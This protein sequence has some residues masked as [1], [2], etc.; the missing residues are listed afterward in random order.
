MVIV[1]DPATGR[2]KRL[3][4]AAGP[5]T[6]AAFS[7]DGVH[8]AFGLEDPSPQQ[9]IFEVYGPDEDGWDEPLPPEVDELLGD[10]DIS[11]EWDEHPERGT[12]FVGQ[13]ANAAT[14]EIEAALYSSQLFDSPAAVD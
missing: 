3:I 6:S 8:V 14:G 7:P 11:T 12:R 1:W 9:P 2:A 4:R 10:Y 5:A 13:I